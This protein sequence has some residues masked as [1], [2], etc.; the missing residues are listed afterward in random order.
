MKNRTVNIL[1]TKYTIEFKDVNQ[2]KKLE[3]LFGYCYRTSKRIVVSNMYR[4]VH[5]VDN[6]EM[7]TNKILKHEIIHAYLYESGIASDTNTQFLGDDNHCEFYI[8]WFA[9]QSEKIFKTFEELGI[10]E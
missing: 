5:S 8:D 3:T 2:D 4:S 1:G 9:M 7:E 6:L 10:S